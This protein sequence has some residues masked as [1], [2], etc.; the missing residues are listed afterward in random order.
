MDPTKFERALAWAQQLISNV[1]DEKAK[2]QNQAR[3]KARDET[4][5]KRHIIADQSVRVRSSPC[6]EV[7]DKRPIG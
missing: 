7:N 6:L 4:C 2:V 1:P 5:G 3:R